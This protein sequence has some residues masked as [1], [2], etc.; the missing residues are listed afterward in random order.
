MAGG[1]RVWPQVI[2]M[3][4]LS[5][6]HSMRRIEMTI[7][8]VFCLYL[9]SMYS[10]VAALATAVCWWVSCAFSVHKYSKM[11]DSVQESRND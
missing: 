8:G 9:L 6:M 5:T 7:V 3:V 4:A 1:E 11:I 2:L 10:G